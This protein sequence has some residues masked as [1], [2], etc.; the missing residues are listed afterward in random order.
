MILVWIVPKRTTT[1]SWI[2]EWH[3]VPPLQHKVRSGYRQK[4]EENTVF[5]LDWSLWS[6]ATIKK[7]EE[8]DE[9]RV[10]SGRSAVEVA[11]GVQWEEGRLSHFE[12]MCYDLGW[13][14]WRRQ[15]RR[16]QNVWE[17]SWNLSL[18]AKDQQQFPVGQQYINHQLSSP[19]P[20]KEPHQL[21]MAEE[22]SAG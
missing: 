2:F 12:L 21:R 3:I 4:K 20:L 9:G 7:K 5:F 16:E 10:W 17:V 8:P 19:Q 11:P 18:R 1:T 6:P 22:K 15:Q 14:K 13:P